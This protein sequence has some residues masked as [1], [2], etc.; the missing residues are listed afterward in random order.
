MSVVGYFWE[1]LG[2]LMQRGHG[3]VWP[4]LSQSHSTVPASVFPSPFHFRNMRFCCKSPQTLSPLYYGWQ[5]LS[6]PTKGLQSCK[7]SQS[8]NLSLLFILQGLKGSIISSSQWVFFLFFVSLE[9]ISVSINMIKPRW[10]FVC[11][12]PTHITCLQNSCIPDVIEFWWF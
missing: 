1:Q 12:L 8:W 10:I 6:I 2:K 9:V 4:F 11:I 7:I 3:L 5:M